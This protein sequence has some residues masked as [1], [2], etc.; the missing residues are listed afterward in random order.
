MVKNLT[1]RLRGAVERGIN[2]TGIGKPEGFHIYVNRIASAVESEVN[3][4]LA[5]QLTVM[6]DLT[7][8]LEQR[9]GRLERLE[10]YGQA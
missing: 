1:G 6:E 7:S 10:Q 2:Y 5:E 8:D 3:A 4:I 9:V